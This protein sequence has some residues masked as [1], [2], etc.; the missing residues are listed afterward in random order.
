MAVLLLDPRFPDVMPFSVAKMEGTKVAYTA[1][2]PIS[3]RW[4]LCDTFPT[5]RDEE[6]ELLITTDLSVEQARKWLAAGHELFQVP[7][8]KF[9]YP[10]V[11]DA[12]EVMAQARKRGEWEAGQTH[13]SLLPY[14]K[15]ET[16]EFIE[17]VESGAS[18]EEIKK[19]LSDIFLQV[20]FHAQIAS[21]RGAFDL[22]D[23]AHAFTEKMHSRA[24]Y[25]FDGSTGRVT[26]EFQDKLWQDGKKQ[27][28]GQGQRQE[29]EP[30]QDPE[31]PS[32]ET[33]GKTTATSTST[34]TSSKF[35]S[36]NRTASDT[37]EKISADATA[38]A[39]EKDAE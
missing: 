24:P 6:A 26:T 18:D 9:K 14:L 19:E 34:S 36:G 11:T 23:V 28:Q 39:S 32:A 31:V 17:A 15:E 4:A 2:V 12:A 37:A 27:E 10:E 5:A 1:E 33:V 3:V 38:R 8:A 21:E 13:T 30:D 16:E 35:V 25:L 22:G 20:L 29:Q 7:T